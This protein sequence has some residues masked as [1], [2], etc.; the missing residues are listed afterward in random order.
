MDLS[1]DVAGMSNSGEGANQ[2]NIPKAIPVSDVQPAQKVNAPPQHDPAQQAIKTEAADIIKESVQRLLKAE[3]LGFD[4]AKQMHTVKLY[5]LALEQSNYQLALKL[6][7]K[8]A[9]ESTQV[10]NMTFKKRIELARKGE[11]DPTKPD[12]ESSNVDTLL[13]VPVKDSPGNGSKTEDKNDLPT[14][15][16][17]TTP[18]PQPS[19]QNLGPQK[20]LQFEHEIQDGQKIYK[21]KKN[22]KKTS[23]MLSIKNWLGKLNNSKFEERLSKAE[24]MLNRAKGLNKSEEENSI[25]TLDERMAKIEMEIQAKLEAEA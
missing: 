17:S 2:S 3:K 19:S 21:G 24:S 13:A 22:E 8:S 18:D 11:I 1:Q 20:V 7:K 10:W 4:T 23:V 15:V 9:I 6:A 16:E 5:R 12:N 25:Q 14:E